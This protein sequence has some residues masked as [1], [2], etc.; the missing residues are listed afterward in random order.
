MKT[1]SLC[2]NQMRHKGSILQTAIKQIFHFVLIPTCPSEVEPEAVLDRIFGEH[3]RETSLEC[4]F[5]YDIKEESEAQMRESLEGWQKE[6]QGKP[7]SDARKAF[8]KYE[9]TKQSYRCYGGFLAM[10]HP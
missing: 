6:F 7:E 2:E 9:E 10:L 3:C 5:A 8:K 4:L 1:L